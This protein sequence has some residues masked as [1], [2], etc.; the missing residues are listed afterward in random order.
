M[1][2]VLLILVALTLILL[3]A[4]YLTRTDTQI[5]GNLRFRTEATHSAGTAYQQL[6]TTTLSFRNNNLGAWA[7]SGGYLPSMALSTAGNPCAASNGGSCCYRPDQQSANSL[8]AALQN[9]IESNLWCSQVAAAGNNAFAIRYAILANSTV[10]NADGSQGIAIL[11]IQKV[12]DPN[13]TS[14]DLIN[15]YTYTVLVAAVDRGRSNTQVIH[16]YTIALPTQ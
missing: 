4:I 2:L 15:F 1:V 10:A 12:A 9:D 7:A 16:N 14:N 3:A 8:V 13:A 11:P 6:L 5:A